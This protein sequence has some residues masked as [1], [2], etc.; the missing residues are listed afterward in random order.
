VW[1]FGVAAILLVAGLLPGLAGSG[2]AA[3]GPDLAVDVVYLDPEDPVEGEPMHAELLVE[4]VGDEDANETQVVVEVDGGTVA[5]REIGPLEAG[6]EDHVDVEWTAEAGDRTLEAIVDPSEAIAEANEANNDA[7]RT[8]TVDALPSP[9]VAPTDLA[10][11]TPAYEETVAGDTIH[12]GVEVGNLVE[13][14]DFEEDATADTFA[15]EIHRDGELVQKTRTEHELDPGDEAFL[16]LGE[17]TAEAG[18]HEIRVVAD[19]A[20]EIDE[21]NETDN[22]ATFTYEV[23]AEPSQPN[24]AVDDVGPAHP[25]E[26]L[27]DGQETWFRADVEH[28]G[29]SAEDVALDLALDGEGFAAIALGSLDRGLGP[30]VSTQDTWVAQ[31]GEH[32]LQATV[33]PAGRVDETNESDNTAQATFTVLAQADPGVVDVDV[34]EPAVPWSGHEVRVDLANPAEGPMVEPAELAVTVCPAEPTPTPECERLDAPE[35]IQLAPGEA[36]QVET[37]WDASGSVGE[38]KIC[39]S[40]SYAPLQADPADDEACASTFALA[41][42]G[43][44]GGVQT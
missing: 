14:D 21:A 40:L 44:I 36:R 35:Q 2:L 6:E 19:V 28:T 41:A 26:R 15:V 7:V 43:A 38:F 25:G 22:G 33:D 1:T 20:D 24:L 18:T 17:R 39:A 29:A 32:T 23:L 4:N 27:I 34:V 16:D 9:N 11:R 10:I 12:L 5:E 3:E 31:A 8:Y 37:A 30:T 42:A 13:V